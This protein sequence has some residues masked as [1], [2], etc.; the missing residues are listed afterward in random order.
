MTPQQFDE[1]FQTMQQQIQEQ[2]VILK[3][4]I[5]SFLAF[6]EQKHDNTLQTV[7]PPPARNSMIEA[8]YSRTAVFRYFC[9]VYCSPTLP[10]TQWH[11]RCTRRSNSQHILPTTCIFY[12]TNG[13][14]D[15]DNPTVPPPNMTRSV[16]RSIIT[17]PTKPPFYDDTFSKG[18]RSWPLTGPMISYCPPWPPP[19]RKRWYSTN[20]DQT[21]R[22]SQPLSHMT[23]QYYR[24]HTTQ[25]GVDL[26]TPTTADNSYPVPPAPTAS[27]KNLLRPP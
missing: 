20:V 22:R 25:Y 11:H 18:K 8:S 21:L 9:E 13:R 16:P 17:A 14:P 3:A 23:T 24:R 2:H 26:S 7:F 19:H 1:A 15:D 5:Q 27:E 6:L 10:D 12:S 4:K